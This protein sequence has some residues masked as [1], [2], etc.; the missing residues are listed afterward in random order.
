M[1]EDDDSVLHA[2]RPEQLLEMVGRGGTTCGRDGVLYQ[3]VRVHVRVRVRVQV[4]IP[5]SDYYI[6]I[7]Y[8]R[9]YNILHYSTQLLYYTTLYLYA[10]ER[11]LLLGGEAAARHD[12]EDGGEAVRRKL[13]EALKLRRDLRV[14][15]VRVLGR[16]NAA[17]RSFLA[18]CVCV[19]GMATT[20]R[21]RRGVRCS[22]VPAARDGRGRASAIRSTARLWWARACRPGVSMTRQGCFLCM[23]SRYETA[24]VTDV[25]ADACSNGRSRPPTIVLH[26]DDFPPPV[27]PNTATTRVAGSTA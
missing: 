25:R 7:S 6:T 21:P 12:D 26:V 3:S 9:C 18:F 5:T 23:K 8:S 2:R 16:G 10:D 19:L 20:R 22:A 14:R 24:F 17:L 13:G 1:R 15:S 11:G 27:M 4:F